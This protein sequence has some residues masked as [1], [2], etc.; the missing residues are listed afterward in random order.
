MLKDQLSLNLGELD[1][2]VANRPSTED[3]DMYGSDRD[4]SPQEQLS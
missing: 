4:Y 2:Y 3:R 1:R